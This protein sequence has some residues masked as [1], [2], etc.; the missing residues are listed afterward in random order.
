MSVNVN[1]HPEGRLTARVDKIKSTGEDFFTLKIE[2]DGK[3]VVTIYADRVSQFK[4]LIDNAVR[5]INNIAYKEE[6]GNA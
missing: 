6:E 4:T 2:D 3:E 1:I 5:D